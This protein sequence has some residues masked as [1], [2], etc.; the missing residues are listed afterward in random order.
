MRLKLIDFKRRLTASILGDCAAPLI[1][2]LII[3]Q[4]TK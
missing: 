4:H 3:W 1:L 2:N